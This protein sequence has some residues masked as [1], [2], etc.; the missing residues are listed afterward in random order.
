MQSACRRITT[1][2]FI[3][4]SQSGMVRRADCSLARLRPGGP[5]VG[6]VSLDPPYRL[7]GP[8]DDFG[9][10]PRLDHSPLTIQAI[11]V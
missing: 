6:L 11:G 9:I 3:Q 1:V 2:D 7:R 5:M 10:L 8:E 4:G